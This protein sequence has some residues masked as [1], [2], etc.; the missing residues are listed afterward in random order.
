[1]CRGCKRYSHE[2]VQWNGYTDAQRKRVR[3]R[4]E[5][6]QAQAVETFVRVIQPDQLSRCCRQYGVDTDNPEDQRSSIYHLLRVLCR[7]GRMPSG[8]AQFDMTLLPRE[9]QEIGLMARTPGTSLRDTFELIEEEF[10]RRSIA[11]FEH[12]FRVPVDA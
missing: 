5:T 9:L 8:M 12:S 2:I 11:H 6:L 4:L 7:A 1:V 10:Y 3:V